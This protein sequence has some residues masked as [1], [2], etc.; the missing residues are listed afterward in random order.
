MSETLVK[1]W[2]DNLFSKKKMQIQIVLK[3]SDT[4]IAIYVRLFW[5]ITRKLWNQ[6]RLHSL[7]FTKMILLEEHH[8]GM[9]FFS[10]IP[11]LSQ[12]SQAFL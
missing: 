3:L 6:D 7:P 9:I 11:L 12:L 1:L 10:D 8:G 5:W 2:L 4:I